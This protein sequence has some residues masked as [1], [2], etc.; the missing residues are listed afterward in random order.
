MG[1]HDNGSPYDE[2][3]IPHWT[4]EQACTFGDGV[5]C[6]ACRMPDAPLCVARG[7]AA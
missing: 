7:G 5:T 2:V 6:P 1:E 4:A 3:V